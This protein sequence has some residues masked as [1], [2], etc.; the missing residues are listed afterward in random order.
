MWLDYFFEREGSNLS[1]PK[2]QN[3]AE[4]EDDYR[5]KVLFL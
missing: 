5:T 1:L 3:K 2:K 4:W